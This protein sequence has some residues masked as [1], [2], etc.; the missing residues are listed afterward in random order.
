MGPLGRV[1]DA[2]RA[3]ACSTCCTRLVPVGCCLLSKQTTSLAGS[4]LSFAIWRGDSGAFRRPPAGCR[5]DASLAQL[6]TY[7]S[8]WAPDLMD[9]SGVSHPRLKRSPGDRAG[10]TGCVAAEGSRPDRER[11]VLSE[12]CVV[13]A[14]LTLACVCQPPSS[15]IWFAV[16][17][18]PA[19]YL[20]PGVARL[21][22]PQWSRVTTCRLDLLTSAAANQRYEPRGSAWPAHRVRDPGEADNRRRSPCRSSVP[23]LRA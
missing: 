12:T 3:R 20:W 1:A 22:V 7:G 4:C 11:E 16:C 8:R 13:L 10:P 23:S 19:S 5:R 21:G 9:R 17:G 6:R 2:P 15:R 18:K 14:D